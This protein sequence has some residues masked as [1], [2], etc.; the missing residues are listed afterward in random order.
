[1]LRYVVVKNTTK[2]VL[3]IKMLYIGHFFM[4]PNAY[5]KLDFVKTVYLIKKGFQLTR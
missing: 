1:M 5:V 2:N 4:I 3:Y